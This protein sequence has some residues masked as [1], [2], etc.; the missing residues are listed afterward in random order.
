M[1]I[2]CALA[3]YNQNNFSDRYFGEAELFRIKNGVLKSQV[4]PDGSQL[5]REK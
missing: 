3:I 4:N 1:E 5:F 2:K